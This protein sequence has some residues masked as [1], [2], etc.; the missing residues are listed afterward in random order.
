MGG[1]DEKPQKETPDAEEEPER[2]LFVGIPRA[3]KAEKA[4]S[5]PAA[6][7][8]GKASDID[9]DTTALYVS[10]AFEVPAFIFQRLTPLEK[11]HFWWSHSA[12]ECAPIAE[13]LT[14]ILN[15]MSPKLKK[16]IKE[17]GNYV[18]L[19]A[20][21]VKVL[22]RPIQME[23]EVHRQYKEAKVAYL[24][25]LSQAVSAN[26]GGAK[27][28]SQRPPSGFEGARSGWLEQGEEEFASDTPI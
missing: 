18:A 15:T 9:A 16:A 28:S 13:P 8:K 20:G 12:E 22:E 10:A 1:L 3:T 21:L 17:N 25:G 2:P 24:R 4:A 14:D 23:I 19:L 6:T 26:G 7:P 11:G 27:R 5:K